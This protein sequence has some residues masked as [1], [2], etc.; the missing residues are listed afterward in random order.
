MGL[1]GRHSF[2]QRVANAFCQFDFEHARLFVD[3]GNAFFVEGEQ[4]KCRQGIAGHGHDRHEHF[5]Q[6]CAVGL[7][8]CASFVAGT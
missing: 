3:G 2:R 1:R 7:Q 6:C 4:N 8:K 5:K